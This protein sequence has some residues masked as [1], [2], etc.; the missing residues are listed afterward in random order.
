MCFHHASILSLLRHSQAGGSA[1]QHEHSAQAWISLMYIFV[2]HCILKKNTTFNLK[3]HY[4]QISVS[5]PFHPRGQVFHIHPPTV[6]INR[7]RIQFLTFCAIA[8]PLVLINEEEIIEIRIS[9][10]LKTLL[11]IKKT[12]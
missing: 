3:K 7:Q 4:F 11:C 2:K 1:S 12:R 10:F 5:F 9:D 8:R 6:N